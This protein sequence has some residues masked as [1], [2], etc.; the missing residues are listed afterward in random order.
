VALE[1]K[2]GSLKLSKAELSEAKLSEDVPRARYLL[3]RSP[4]LPNPRRNRPLIGDW[5]KESSGDVFLRQLEER[6]LKDLWVS[7][8]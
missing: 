1:E 2:L 6:W 3:S 7:S 5:R 8:G 4:R